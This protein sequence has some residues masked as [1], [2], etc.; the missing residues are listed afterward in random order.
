[1]T[2]DQTNRSGKATAVRSDSGHLGSSSMDLGNFAP[3]VARMLSAMIQ[4]AESFGGK[5][6]VLK[7]TPDTYF[8]DPNSGLTTEY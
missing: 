6:S 7:E 3:K 1:M 5:D 2:V 4:N 8:I